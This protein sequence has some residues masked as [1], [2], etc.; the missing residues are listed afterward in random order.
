ML[1]NRYFNL[2]FLALLA[3]GCNNTGSEEAAGETSGNTAPASKWADTSIKLPE[4]FQAIV[5][6]D[7]VGRARHIAVRENGDIYIQLSREQDGKGIAALRDEDGDGRADRIEYFGNHTGTGM[8]IHGNFLY[9]SS[10]LAVYRYPLP[11]GDELLPDETKRELVAGGFPEQSSHASKSLTLDGEGNLFVNVGAPSN[12]CMYESRTKGSTGQDPCPQLE[13]HAGIWEFKAGKTEQTQQADGERYATGLRNCVAVEWN[14]A[15]KSLFVL[16]HGRDQLSYLYPELYSDQDNAEL[17]AE[18]FLSVSP[19]DD[20]GWPYCYFDQRKGQKLLA[21]EYG[22]D[23]IE[24][25]RCADIK[26]PLV[27]FP[28]HMAPN[29]LVFYTAARFP[30][31]YRNGAFIAFHGSWNRAPLPQKGYFVAFVPMKDGQ[32]SGD[33][34]IFADNIAG[35]E[36]IVSPRDA[37]HRPTGLAVGPDGAL[38]ITDSVKGKV[39]KV[40]Y[41][42]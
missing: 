24:Q 11:E 25:G 13:L 33:W 21:P 27:A 31:K 15:T 1:K 41:S 4:G 7:S 2:F 12:A 19:G 17:P 9:C 39:W 23:G 22:G 35:I 32:P 5:V 38:Y 8:D 26:K 3:F 28:G 18:E 10:D 30:E 42:G 37:H 40:V 16:Q 36:N 29:D 14:P 6:A 20:F 34:E